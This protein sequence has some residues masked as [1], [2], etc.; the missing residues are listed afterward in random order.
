MLTTINIV[1]RSDLLKSCRICQRFQK[2][3]KV[4]N[5][6]N[7]ATVRT[8]AERDIQE[9]WEHEVSRLLHEYEAHDVPHREITGRT[10]YFMSISEI[11]RFANP[12]FTR[13]I[14]ATVK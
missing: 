7:P 3:R 10:N 12:Q 6:T 5:F 13:N 14:K 11:S 4:L 9:S 8:L 1:S 2:D